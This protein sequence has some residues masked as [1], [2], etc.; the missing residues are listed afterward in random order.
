[1]KTIWQNGKEFSQ[2]WLINDN[3]IDTVNLGWW[4]LQRERSKSS[5]A[6]GVLFAR[7]EQ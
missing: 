3:N 1:M 6:V 4:A 5:Q 7:M 2:F